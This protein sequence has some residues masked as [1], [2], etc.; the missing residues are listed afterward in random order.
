MKTLIL[1]IITLNLFAGDATDTAMLPKACEDI[2]SQ[3][4]KDSADRAKKAISALEAQKKANAKKPEVVAL[5]DVEI[6]K[7]NKIVTESM[8]AVK[9]DWMPGGVLP[10]SEKKQLDEDLKTGNKTDWVTKAFER[11][12]WNAK[13]STEAQF[14][15]AILEAMVLQRKT[16]ISGFYF[17]VIYPTRTMDMAAVTNFFK[18]AKSVG[19]DYGIYAD[20]FEQAMPHIRELVKEVVGGDKQKAAWTALL[21]YDVNDKIKNSIE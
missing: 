20:I 14:K 16:G 1:F 9:L 12:A 7:F 8:S 2:V 10:S 13:L 4:M 17:R 18:A 3:Y 19:A 6:V 15:G 5:I 11:A 21:P